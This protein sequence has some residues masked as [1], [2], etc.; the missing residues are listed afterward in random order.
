LPSSSPEIVVI[1]PVP[2]DSPSPAVTPSYLIGIPSP[3]VD[4]GVTGG[5]P[6]PLGG[7]FNDLPSPGPVSA[8]SDNGSGGGGFPGPLMLIGMLL[9]VGAV[10]SILWAIAPKGERFPEQ[11]SGGAPSVVF[12]PSGPENP[13][14]MVMDQGSDQP[15][16]TRTR[17]P[18]PST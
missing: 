17:R 12:T 10:G 18:R 2:L 4:P 3:S 9:L 14:L 8:V 11:P 15:S 16:S 7:G 1:S 5:T 13:E 6:I